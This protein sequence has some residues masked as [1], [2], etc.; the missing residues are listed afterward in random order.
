MDTKPTRKTKLTFVSFKAANRSQFTFKDR[1]KRTRT[2]AYKSPRTHAHG[3]HHK[4][5]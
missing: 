3:K 2:G 4:H 1:S 5:V